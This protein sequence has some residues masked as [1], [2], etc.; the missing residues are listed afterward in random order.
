MR[1]GSLLAARFPT[2]PPTGDI[3]EVAANIVAPKYGSVGELVMHM[4]MFIRSVY[5][6]HAFLS[7]T[8]RFNLLPILAGRY[9]NAYN[10]GSPGSPERA[11]DEEI[12]CT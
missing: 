6:Q 12:Y 8:C 7:R 11:P 2:F 1:P 10:A 9:S 3:L 5:S 4:C